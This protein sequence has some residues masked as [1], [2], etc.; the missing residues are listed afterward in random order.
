MKITIRD[1]VAGRVHR[2]TFTV[3]L[4]AEQTFALIEGLAGYPKGFIRE[5]LDK[6]TGE[7]AVA[8][9]AKP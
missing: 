2:M 9:E 1:K 6:P 5:Q 8:K 4:T 3:N 7:T